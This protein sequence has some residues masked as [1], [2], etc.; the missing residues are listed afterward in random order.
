MITE[1][2]TEVVRFP[3][4]PSTHGGVSVERR[5][6]V[7]RQEGGQ[8]STTFVTNALTYAHCSRIRK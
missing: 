2:Q 1:D 3:T 6:H 8:I 5:R 4:S 7:L